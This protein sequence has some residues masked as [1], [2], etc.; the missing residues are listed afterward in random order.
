M[1]GDRFVGA[2]P[3]RARLCGVSALDFVGTGHD[4]SLQLGQTRGSVPTRMGWG[5]C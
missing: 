1:A 3:C 4:L 5:I 2:D